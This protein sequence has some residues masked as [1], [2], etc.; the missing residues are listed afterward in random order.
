MSNEWRPGDARIT[1][2]P[3]LPRRWTES[4]R[5]RGKRSRPPPPG[6]RLRACLAGASPRQVF[7]SR[8]GAENTRDHPR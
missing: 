6:R 8:R 5:R 1:T 7:F 2:P 4:T 3:P